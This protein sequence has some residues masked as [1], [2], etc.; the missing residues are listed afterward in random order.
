[1]LRNFNKVICFLLTVML[2]SGLSLNVSAS[3]MTDTER[4]EAEGKNKIVFDNGDVA[5]YDLTEENLTNP[6]LKTSYKSKTV[7]GRFYLTSSGATVAEYSLSATFSYDGDTVGQEGH[8]VWIGNFASGWSGEAVD[9]YNWISP[10]YMYI[11]GYYDL[12]KDGEYNN[13]H[14][15]TLYCDQYGNITVG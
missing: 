1:M 15:L 9:G 5:Y 12:Y 2:L 3:E 14:T 6:I 13:S 4:Y 8:R 10:Q 7:T 11:N